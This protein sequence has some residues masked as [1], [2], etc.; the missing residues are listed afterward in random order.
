M[1]LELKHTN[2]PPLLLEFTLSQGLEQ[3]PNVPLGTVNEAP[4]QP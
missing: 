3:D 2:D 4:V 1:P